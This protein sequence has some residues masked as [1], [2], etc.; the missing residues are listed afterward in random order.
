LWNEN[1]LQ[2]INIPAKLYSKYNKLVLKKDYIVSSADVS[3]H[4][5]DAKIDNNIKWLDRT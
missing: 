5:I 3:I 2:P 4:L 1:N